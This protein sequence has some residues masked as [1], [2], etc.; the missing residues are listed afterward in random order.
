M[1]NDLILRDYQ[2][3]AVAAVLDAGNQGRQR[4]L[5]ALPT[6]TGKTPVAVH[7]V[8]A[9]AGRALFLVHRDELVAQA[10]ERFA[11]VL[12]SVRVGVV[13]AE[14]DDGAAPIVIASVQTLARPKRLERLRDVADRLGQPFT[15]IV[16]D[17]AHHAVATSYRAV[18]YGLGAIARDPIATAEAVAAAQAR[19]RPA[20]RAIIPLRESVPGGPLV[21]GLT[22]TPARG[23]GL[24]LDIVFQSIVYQRTLLEMI[25]AGWLA[26]LRVL[27]VGSGIDLAGVRTTTTEQGRDY[28]AGQL[29][30]ALMAQGVPQE[31]AAAYLAHA[32]ER[33]ALVFVP[34]VEMAQATT[35]AFQAANV[36]TGLVTGSTPPAERQQVIAALR[37]R[38]LRV[39]VNVAVLTEGFDAPAVDCII[40]GRPTQRRPLYTQI[41]G[42]GTR[43]YPGK[44][45]CLVLELINRNL[46]HKVVSITDLTGKPLL[47]G[48]S[49]REAVEPP[50]QPASPRIDR[51]AATMPVNLFA[52]LLW[53][54]QPGQRFSLPAGRDR[55]IWLVAVDE[56]HCRVE[57]REPG[58]REPLFGGRTLRLDYAQ[59]MVEDL[60][61]REG[62]FWLADARATWRAAPATARQR[63]TMRTLGLRGAD[64]ETLTKGAASAAIHG[65]FAA[66]DGTRAAD[67]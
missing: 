39:L 6:G 5:C 18:L 30:A 9:R 33:T 61:R 44:A 25:V 14:R 35:A 40:V 32:P 16:V 13:K 21:L 45:D 36:A 54:P 55:T 67:E 47:R 62:W 1:S 26:D 56:L 29:G 12:P 22:A 51:V 43:T 11:A 57:R 52:S 53:Q 17:E 8:A 23:D 19:G 64:A 15:T 41:I 63:E 7:V 65:F 49:V 58:K 66:R 42:R 10:L 59:G 24:G 3:A 4:I 46:R 2:R 31:L 37:R 48:Q 60:A 50:P 28:D 34:S 38:E 20:P 27:A